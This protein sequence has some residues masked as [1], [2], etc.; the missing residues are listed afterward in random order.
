MFCFGKPGEGQ[1]GRL[2][3]LSVRSERVGKQHKVPTGALLA[4]VG[5]QDSVF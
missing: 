5:N 1:E 4:K 3:S 2:I